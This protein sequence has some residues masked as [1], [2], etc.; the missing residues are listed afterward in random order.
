MA[1]CLCLWGRVPQ[2][3]PTWCQ[4]GRGSLRGLGGTG[5]SC[6]GDNSAFV[7]FAWM[8]ERGWAL[9]PYKGIFWWGLVPLSLL[10]A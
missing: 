9:L 5:P 10:W 4:R 8:P 1:A 3:T 6:R 7:S 2:A